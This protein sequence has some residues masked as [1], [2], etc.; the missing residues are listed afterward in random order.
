M[1]HLEHINLLLQKK[2]E[3]VSKENDKDIA[4]SPFYLLAAD[5]EKEL[6]SVAIFDMPELDYLVD[7]LQLTNF[8]KDVLLLV[9]AVEIDSK[10]E[11]IYAYL[12]DD[13][14]KKYP[15]VHFIADILT[16]PMVTKKEILNYFSTDSKLSLLNLLEFLQINHFQSSFQDAIRVSKSLKS[17]L[18]G[19][20]QLDEKIDDYCKLKNFNSDDNTKY[21]SLTK[22]LKT[23]IGDN[24]CYLFN[25]YG[26][27][28][29]ES[30]LKAQVI[31]QSFG[32]SLLYISS[33]HIPQ[34]LEIHELMRMLLR[35]ALLSNSLL[36]FDDF[37]A[38][39]RERKEDENFLLENLE[40]FSWISFFSTIKIWSPQQLF[41]ELNFVTIENTL[42][43]EKAVQNFW[44]EALYTVDKHLG[45]DL[46]DILAQH[47]RFTPEKIDDVCKLLRAKKILGQSINNKEV[48]KTCRLTV[49]NNLSEYAQHLLSESTLDDI[50][51]LDES[52]EQLH[53]VL[54]HYQY[55]FHVFE[56]WNFKKHFQSRGLGVLFS[57]S[58]GTGK[59][60]AASILA[61]E[62]GLELYRVELS[63][64]VSKYIGETEKNLANIFDIAEQSG[65]VLF[66]DEADAIF[67]KRSQTQDAHDRYANIEV[68]YLLQKIEAYNGLV[69]LASNFKNNID[70]AFL[71]RMRFV[72]DFPLPNEPQR[73]IIWHRIFSKEM[74][75]QNIDFEYLA[76]NFKLSGANIRNAAL[77][78]AF[79][80]LEQ[81]TS[82]NMGS[83]L[84]GVKRELD[85]I[86]K[87]I[88]EEEYKVYL[89][90]STQ[91]VI[92]E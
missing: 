79:N 92:Y 19:S 10:Y 43:T 26:A 89:K 5:I 24:Q 67:G 33:S 20:F 6:S 57:G 21:S 37:E 36:F 54:S 9:F 14:N 8:E 85:K 38:F 48:L 58:S 28:K 72:I 4:P 63:K 78:A 62:L 73:K 64:I 11:R 39:L 59:T 68:S 15:T 32:F 42:D 47:F 91:G 41:G 90:E 18:L 34:N 69:I 1:T 16:T 35:D 70:E 86:G 2:F 83:I 13:M 22:T 51:L 23:T 12:Q 50:T 17:F 65:V 82:V 25:L 49:E 75:I 88:K 80:A 29:K 40:K 46:A 61:N 77:Y 53:E 3:E 84:K 76:K 27:S 45:D 74:N 31:A 44:K 71:R 55:Q 87:P 66:F 52:K 30:M 81:N 56:K 7:K 60:M